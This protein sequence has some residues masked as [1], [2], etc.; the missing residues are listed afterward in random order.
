MEH[1]FGSLALLRLKVVRRISYFL[2]QGEVAV[3]V[4]E[5]PEEEVLQVGMAVEEGAVQAEVL[6]GS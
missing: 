1:S 4:E 6:L 5:V 3:L 2:D